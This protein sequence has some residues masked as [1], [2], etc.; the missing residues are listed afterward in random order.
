MKASRA[1]VIAVLAGSGLATAEP[2]YT[3][4]VGYVSITCLPNSDTI[5]GLPLRTSA[6]YTGALSAIPDT[7]T[8][9][10]S[11][12]LS[13][14][15][16]PGLTANEFAGAYYVK[17]K[18]STPAATGDGQWFSITANGTSS[19]TVDLNGGTIAAVS[20]AQL[21]VLKFWTLA[22]LFPPSECTTDPATTGNAIVASLN[23]LANGR[24]T[25]VLVPDLVTPGTNL[26]ASAI[27]YVYNG[28]WRKPG[29]AQDFGSVQ[30][31]PDVYFT[32]RHSAAITSPT[33]YTINGEV[34]LG[35]FVAPLT[36]Q[37][38]IYQDNFVAIPRPVD[39]ALNQLNLGGTDAFVSST[40]TLASGRRDQLLVFDNATAAY[41]KA[42]AAIYY[43]HNG[44]WK[45]PG[46]A[47]DQG[48]VVIPAGT[49]FII[50]KYPTVDGRTILWENINHY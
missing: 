17:F 9:P 37:A 7:T 34:E 27:Y 18:D 47:A 48:S 36:T 2:V 42:A 12:I 30:L 39:T 25:Q 15:G 6:A 3:S 40:S 10:G 35:E 44:I 45:K 41:N 8:T 43:F 11:A 46:S 49:G 13:L 26:A 21:E 32:I 5:V 14:S 28:Q 1:L 38:S 23:T 19:I 4:P 29:T 33:T 20:G 50:R 16:N 31:W 24:R 22:E